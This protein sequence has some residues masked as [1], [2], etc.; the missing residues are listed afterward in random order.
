MKTSSTRIFAKSTA[1]G[2]TLLAMSNTFAT[3]PL[4]VANP[5]ARDLQ[6][7]DGLP[8]MRRAR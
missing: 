2:Y 3:V 6:F 4:F 1:D 8:R 5:Y 7:P